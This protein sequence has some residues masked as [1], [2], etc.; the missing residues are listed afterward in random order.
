MIV[1][2]Y[3]REYIYNRTKKGRKGQGLTRDFDAFLTENTRGYFGRWHSGG[4]NSSQHRRGRGHWTASEGVRI[5]SYKLWGTKSCIG[6]WGRIQ[7][8]DQKHYVK[9]SYNHS[10]ECK[11]MWRDYLYF[12]RGEGLYKEI[13][14]SGV[15]LWFL[16]AL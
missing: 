12:R 7:N 8:D 11:P 10:I 4:C 15:L 16:G 9:N 1:K 14:R 2:K 5:L 6:K 3:K 13:E